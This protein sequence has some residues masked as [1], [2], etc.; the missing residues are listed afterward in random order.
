MDKEQILENCRLIYGAFDDLENSC[1]EVRETSEIRTLTYDLLSQDERAKLILGESYQKM[2]DELT[3]MINEFFE[4]GFA[5]G[6]AIGNL[7]DSPYPKVKKAIK[8]IQ[9]LLKEKALLPYF[10]RER[11]EKKAA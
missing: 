4:T 7:F 2:D 10:P 5:F 9:T 6:Y 1:D 8:E 11:R 3:P